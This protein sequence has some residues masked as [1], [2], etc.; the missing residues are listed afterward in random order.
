MNMIQYAIILASV[1]AIVAALALL[2]KYRSRLR[3]LTQKLKVIEDHDYDIHY[4]PTNTLIKIA[5]QE[6]IRKILLEEDRLKE[7][8]DEIRE[9]KTRTPLVVVV[10]PAGKIALKDG[11]HRVLAAKKLKFKTMPIKVVQS[12][13]IV[14]HGVHI[15]EVLAELLPVSPSFNL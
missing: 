6:R 8:M 10:D 12:K 15:N 1:V 3:I 5:N 2:F 11:H 7:V 4:V 13:R 9:G 14:S